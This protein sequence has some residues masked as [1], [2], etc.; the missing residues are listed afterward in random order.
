M[1][2]TTRSFRDL[3]FLHVGGPRVGSVVWTGDAMQHWIR[4]RAR[5]IVRVRDALID[6]SH[7]WGIGKD[8]SRNR[9]GSVRS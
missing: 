7:D 1:S 6:R 2:G 8:D 5:S 3:V 9:C 4:L